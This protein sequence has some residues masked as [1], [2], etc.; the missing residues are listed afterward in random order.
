MEVLLI[1]CIFF[2]EDIQEG[3]RTGNLVCGQINTATLQSDQRKS[4]VN[5]DSTA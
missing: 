3:G 2:W 1:A 5:M 4:E